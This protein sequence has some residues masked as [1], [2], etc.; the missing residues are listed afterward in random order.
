MT[1]EDLQKANETLSTMDIKGKNYV[2]VN[3]RVKAFRMLYPEGTITTEILS[4]EN[5]VVTMQAKV[6]DAEGKLLST[7]LAYE[8]ET[9][10]FINKTS[11]I[12]NCETSAVGRALGF[13]GI[14]VDTSIASY[15]EVQNAVNNQ[16]EQKPKKK[17]A[18]QERLEAEHPEDRVTEKEAID[19]ANELVKAGGN[20]EWF[21]KKYKVN[22][23]VELTPAQMVEIYGAIDDNVRKQKQAN[24]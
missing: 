5:G 2:L 3:E 21:L 22:A 1:F 14:G 24:S 18:Y 15:E 19:L 9:S 6:M 10:S 13:L 17:S 16:G 7:G 20:I 23:F 8:K 11:Y 4:L 12:E